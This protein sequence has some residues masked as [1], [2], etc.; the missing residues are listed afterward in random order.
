MD[1]ITN[2]QFETKKYT[3]NEMFCNNKFANA[4][5]NTKFVNVFLHTNF[6]LYY[7]FFFK[8][9]YSLAFR[10]F[11]IALTGGIKI[12]IDLL[13]E[14]KSILIQLFKLDVHHLVS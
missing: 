13:Y 4:Q 11:L 6:L 9:F 7:L 8:L 5:Q 12:G 2:W 1:A 10:I 14:T 3:L